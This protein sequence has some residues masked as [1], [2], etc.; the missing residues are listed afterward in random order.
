MAKEGTKFDIATINEPELLRNL[1]QNAKRLGNDD[2]YWEA[3][4]QLCFLSGIREGDPLTRDFAQTLVAYEELLT[5]KNGRTT[6]ATRTRQKVSNKGVRQALEDWALSTNP[7][8]GF[9]LLM[10]NGLEELTGEYLVVKYADQ[11]S[12]AV[13]AAANAR[14]A[15]FKRKSIN[16]EN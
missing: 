13:V 2:V 1:M 9:K 11:F 3:F 4:R 5:E 15:D 16:K 6:R 14:L 10:D 7:T 12:P 8:D